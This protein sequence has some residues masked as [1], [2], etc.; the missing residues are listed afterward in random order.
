MVD[1]IDYGP[2]AMC[3]TCGMICCRPGQ[4]ECIECIAP[5]GDRPAWA[6]P[7]DR[8]CRCD[9]CWQDARDGYGP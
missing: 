3:V 4:A 5:A 7:H 9:R 6:L 1:E 8:A 2:A